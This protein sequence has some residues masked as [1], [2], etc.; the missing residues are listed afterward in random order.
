MGRWWAV[1]EGGAA[2][3]EGAV[4][5]GRPNRGEGF[6]LFIFQFIFNFLLYIYIYIRDFLGVKNEMLCET[7]RVKCH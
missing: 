1:G 5:Q 3:G 6:F 2:R 4:G 7:T